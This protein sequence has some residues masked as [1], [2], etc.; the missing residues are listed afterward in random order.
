VT[1]RRQV[2]PAAE[3]DC[4]SCGACCFSD[5]D[6]STYVHLSEEDVKRLPK[7]VR[8][9]VISTRCFPGDRVLAPQ[10]ATKHAAQ[11]NCVCALFEGEIGKHAGCSVYK[12]RPE[13][14]QRFPV[15][16]SGCRL[17]REVAG[18]EPRTA[19]SDCA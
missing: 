4:R 19:L 10:L 3:L 16:G 7:R 1:R 13:V 9:H 6:E 14:C 11:G 5:F 12:S 8:L 15:G 18:L 2:T 17:A